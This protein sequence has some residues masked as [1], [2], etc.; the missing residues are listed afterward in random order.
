[1]GYFDNIKKSFGIELVYLLVFYI[2]IRGLI[3]YV[4]YY[5]YIY[6]FFYLLLLLG[7]TIYTYVKDKDICNKDG[8]NKNYS[9]FNPIYKSTFY[10]LFVILFSIILLTLNIAPVIGVFARIINKI[11]TLRHLLGFIVVYIIYELITAANANEKCLNPDGILLINNNKIYSTSLIVLI[12]MIII[13]I[14]YMI[15][16][17]NR[18][19][20]KNS[21]FYGGQINNNFYP[22]NFYPNNFYPNI[23]N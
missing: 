19:V 2:I 1:M 18:Y 11:P 5:Y 20:I 3:E 7:I 13:S 15:P 16:F 8:N 17:L 10:L 6:I 21:M 22:N 14:F 9:I 4:S 12:Y 23:I